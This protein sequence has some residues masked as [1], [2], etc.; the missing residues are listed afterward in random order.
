MTQGRTDLLFRWGV[1]SSITAILSFVIG[2]PWGVTGVCVAF[3]CWNIL[4][5][6]PLMTYAG[7]IIDLPAAEVGRTIAG[8]GVAA[9]SWLGASGRWSPRFL[10]AGA[11][12]RSSRRGSSPAPSSTSSRC[13]SSR[14][15]HTLS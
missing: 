8:V 14:R 5:A 6:Y 15:S 13:R 11:P 7:R 2:L 3:T 10:P 1:V 12:W 9:L 4:M